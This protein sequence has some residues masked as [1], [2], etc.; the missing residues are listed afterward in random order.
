MLFVHSVRYLV[1]LLV[2]LMEPPSTCWLGGV[3]T[4]SMK[5]IYCHVLGNTQSAP[6]RARH[7]WYDTVE[8]G[9]TS[10]FS[11]KPSHI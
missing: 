10:S 8:S 3:R 4:R 2:V 1:T 7:F 6:S 5:L 9:H 11:Y